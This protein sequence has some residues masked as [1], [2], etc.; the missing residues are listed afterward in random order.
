MTTSFFFWLGGGHF[1]SSRL[2]DRFVNKVNLIDFLI[3]KRM[4]KVFT[5]VICGF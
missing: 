1:E 2:D 4:L 5:D 3:S